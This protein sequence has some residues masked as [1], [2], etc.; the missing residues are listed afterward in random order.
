[1]SAERRHPQKN[2]WFFRRVLVYAITIFSMFMISY[3]GFHGVADSQ[4]HILIAT[5]CFW[6]LAAVYATYVLGATTD[7]I[8][9][10]ARTVRGQV[11]Q[12]TEGK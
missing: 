1:M 7:D 2:S 3:L 5:G 8:L 11:E 12:H 6:L 9:T 10:M 4:L